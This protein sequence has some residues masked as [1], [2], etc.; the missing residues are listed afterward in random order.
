[1]KTSAFR[2]PGEWKAALLTLPDKAYFDL[3][4]CVFGSVK[5]PFSKHRLMEDLTVFLNREEIQEIIGAYIDETD[6]RLLTAIA[7][8]DE[9]GPGDLESFFAGEYSYLELQS[10][11]LNLEERLILYRF[12]EDDRYHLALNPLLEPVLAPRIA[13]KSGLFPSFPA[14]ETEAPGGT[15]VDDRTLAAL[16][17][18]VSGEPDFFKNEG[19]IRKKVLE[20]G[21]K[22]FSGLDMEVLIGGLREI[23]L[24][25]RTG[26][27]YRGDPGRCAF[28][29]ELPPGDRRAYWAAGIS[30]Y[31]KEK[32][33]PD[34]APHYVNRTKAVS[35]ARFIRRLLDALEPERRYP[36]ETLRRLVEMLDRGRTGASP[37]KEAFSFPWLRT[38]PG[39]KDFLD[40]LET[41]GLLV[42]VEPDRWKLGLADGPAAFP[43][44]MAKTPG[45]VI[46]MDAVFSCILY[47]EIDF[48]DALSLASFCAV[49]ETGAVVRFELTRDSVIRGFDQG[50]NAAAMIALLDKLSGN[51]AD[52]NLAWTLADW[53]KRYSAVALH[54]G[55]VLC[56]AE[57][58]R[59]LVEKGPL[60]AL[61]AHTLAPGVYLLS[62][63]EQDEAARE[64]FRAGVDIIAQPPLSTA[65]PTGLTAA[66]PAGNTARPG[67]S[68]SPGETARPPYPALETSPRRGLAPYPWLSVPPPI[69]IAGEDADRGAAFFQDRFRRALAKLPLAA[70]EREELAARIER[71]LIVNES[72][73]AGG[74]VRSEKTEAR[75]LDYVGKTT[76]AKQAIASKS[77]LE[78]QWF[79]PGGGLNRVMGTPQALEKQGGDTILVL[80]PLESPAAD[81]PAPGIPPGT[82]GTPASPE[83]P[84]TL[85][86]S[87][88]KI[89][90]LRRIKQS[91]FGE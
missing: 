34:V 30:L 78:I 28:F 20:E 40:A 12:R 62:L 57:D 2:S 89:S 3:M 39:F 9:P 56:L 27:R 23:G 60:A 19:G 70:P 75:N 76:I 72:Q 61:I 11:L 44:A 31:L 14:A 55:V 43:P 33:E 65:M 26:L 85:K 37:G 81:L 74:T 59:Y 86:V 41:T 32:T 80:R 46:A 64:L 18:F 35:L 52:Q 42:A 4:R 16:F 53:E 6:R 45:P 17:A 36:R 90:L 1:M 71:R 87:L 8:L 51:R 77:L 83:I 29:K 48:A 79:S 38:V 58:R 5:T 10:L 13:D 15:A 68:E 24:I 69:R 25:S 63:T 22:L 82:P 73:L 91:I 49:R 54:R 67:G 84:Q 50:L 7:A 88:G 66:F 21:N 47:P